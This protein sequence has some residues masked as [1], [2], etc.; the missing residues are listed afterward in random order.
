MNKSK[1]VFVIIFT[2]ALILIS[3]IVIDYEEHIIAYVSIAELQKN[4]VAYANKDIRVPGFL[5][6]GEFSEDKLTFSFYLCDT[7]DVDDGIKVVHNKAPEL[8]TTSDGSP[9]IVIGRLSSN[10]ITASQV[11]T[12]CSSKYEEEN[13]TY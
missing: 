9:I 7:K 10:Q 5:K 12:K 8:A 4:P 11:L 1:Q 3:W 2:L 13:T 6:R